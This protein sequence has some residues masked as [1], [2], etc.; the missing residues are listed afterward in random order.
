ME[1]WANAFDEL[2]MGQWQLQNLVSRNVEGQLANFGNKVNVPLTPDFGAADDWTPGSAISGINISQEEF[3]VTLNQSKKKT[4]N[5]NGTE[6]AKSGYDLVTEYGV[7]MAKSIVRSVNEYI[8]QTALGATTLVDATAGI[9]EDN[10][11]DA[12]TSLSNNE[13]S[14]DGRVLVAGPDVI[15]ALLK[16]DAFQYANNSGTDIA[17]RE[18]L[19]GRKFA[20]DFYENNALTKYT[21]A[22]LVGAIDGD[23]AAGVSTFN[24]TGF[25]DDT[26][27]IRVGDIFTV[28]GDTTKY[29]V[30]GTTQTAGDTTTLVF[31]PALVADPAANAVVTVTPTQSAL[32]MVPSGIAFAA[33]AYNVLPAQ[34]GVSQSIINVSGL[35]IR[36]SV[37]QD[38]NLGL[39]VQYDILFGATLAKNNRVVRI[40]E[41]L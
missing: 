38:G 36:I 29:T 22:D 27:P 40:I 16:R 24:V 37:W 41:D 1:F 17:M 30:T 6:L 10:I 19:L 31:S 11:V 25:D 21:P 39:L 7:P 34:T 9:T 8:Y 33:R 13:V 2:D 5:L 18:G 3:E 35:P 23:V 32:A 20:F 4:I 15:G 12:K 26:N 14:M 28:A